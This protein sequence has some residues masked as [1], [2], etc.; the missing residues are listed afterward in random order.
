MTIRQKGISPPMVCAGVVVLGLFVGWQAR[1]AN[2]TD[3]ADTNWYQNAQTSFTISNSQQLAGLAVLVNVGVTNF[4]GKTVLLTSS[5]SLAGHDWTAIGT[6]GNAFRGTFDGG[7]QVISDLTINLPSAN[8]QGLFGYIGDFGDVSYEAKRAKVRNVTL[9]NCVVRGCEKAGGLVGFSYGWIENCFTYGGLVSGTNDVGGIVGWSSYSSILNCEN[10]GGQVSGWDYVGGV[11]GHV[12]SSEFRNAGNRG[13]VIGRS[14]VGGVAG[15]ADNLKNAYNT[16]SVTGSVSNVGGVAGG[17]STVLSM[18]NCFHAGTMGGAG[19]AQGGVVGYLS[20]GALYSSYWRLGAGSPSNAIGVQWGGTTSSNLVAFTDTVSLISSSLGTNTVPGAMNKWVSLNAATTPPYKTWGIM[21]GTN[22]GYPVFLPQANIT[23]YANGGQFAGG[24]STTNRLYRPQIPYSDFPAVSWAGGALECWTN[25]A[26]ESATAS[27]M[28]GGDAALYAKWTSYAGILNATNLTVTSSGNLPWYGQAAVTHDGVLAAQSGGITHSQASTLETT[29]TGPGTLKFWWKVSSEANYD[30][31]KLFLGAAEQYNISGTVDWQQ[32]TIALPGGQTT[33]K[34]TYMKDSSASGGSDAGWVDQVE[35]LPN[36]VVTLRSTEGWFSGGATLT[37]VTYLLDQPFGSFPVATHSNRLF[38]AWTNS[39]GGI[40]TKND[41]VTS[42]V[43]NL[44]A[45]W[46]SQPAALPYTNG[47]WE[48]Y[49]NLPT[50][51]AAGDA[52]GDGVDN[53]TE[54]V[55]G[56]VPTNSAS[57][58]FRADIR[59]TNGVPVITWIP[60]LGMDRIYSL[61]GK[62]ALDDSTWVTPTNV[63][64]RYFRIQVQ[65]P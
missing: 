24:S 53:Y 9:T 1:A 55:T 34:W 36:A 25:L 31:L 49:Y 58:G 6:I 26:G 57:R 3:F 64:T 61:E 48:A 41:L 44:A 37:N 7:T 12:T 42:S 35:W 45:R 30:K 40:V 39:T 56:T 65:A 23:F 46:V 18:E 10:M 52:D 51:S 2:W 32:R 11:A 8:Y 27:S 5:V 4:S 17:V 62:A 21:P 50:N 33:V 54:W 22:G 60:D 38:A 20:S 43:T 16:G 19:T 59:F 47:A 15:M 29:V 14:Y 63:N 28:V 13:N